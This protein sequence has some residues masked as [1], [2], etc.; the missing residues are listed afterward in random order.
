MQI[1][2]IYYQIKRCINNR[3]KYNYAIRTR[4]CAVALLNAWSHG[5]LTP[6][7]AL[8]KHTKITQF[9]ILH[10]FRTNAVLIN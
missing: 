1:Q 10:H 2:S 5:Q 4:Y 3:L 8:L 7:M 9:E 6:F